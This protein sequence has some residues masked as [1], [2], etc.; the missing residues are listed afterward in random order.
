MKEKRP[1]TNPSVLRTCD[2]GIFKVK[3]FLSYFFGRKFISLYVSG[4]LPT[5]GGALKEFLGEDV[6]LGPWNP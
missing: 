6:P 1:E 4:K 3:N 2:L 5:P